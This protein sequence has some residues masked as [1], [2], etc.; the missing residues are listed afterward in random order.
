MAVPTS[1]ITKPYKRHSAGDDTQKLKFRSLVLLVLRHAVACYHGYT[2]DWTHA[3]ASLSDGDLTELLRKALWC[4]HCENGS[5]RLVE[6]GRVL[7]SVD[8]G[9]SRGLGSAPVYRLSTDR[10]SAAS[11]GERHGG[12]HW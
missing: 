4:V 6:D 1:D 9:P 10:A 11:A 7:R 5:R 12:H 3:A 2:E 8:C